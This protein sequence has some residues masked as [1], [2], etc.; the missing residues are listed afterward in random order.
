MKAS[1]PYNFAVM[2]PQGSGKGTQAE[3][4]A[5]KFKL[6]YIG[7]GDALRRLAKQKTPFGRKVDLIINKQGKLVPVSWVVELAKKEI[8]KTTKN[9]GLIFD[10]FARLLPE[11]K[12]INQTLKKAGRP[13]TAV[14]LIDISTKE[15]VKRLIR[16]RQCPNG[17]LFVS[18]VTL[19]KSQ[20]NC[21]RCGARIFQREDDRPAAIRERLRNY[22]RRTKPA[23]DYF[24]KEGLLVK[25]NGEQPVKKVFSDILRV[26]K[27][28]EK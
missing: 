15:T 3:L 4:L 6:K 1:K 7:A 26:I 9:Q 16:R 18:G 8:K 28:L 17:H 2:G 12:T 27:K 13:I 19:K 10:G 22:H 14:F 20:K 5:K 25:I 24:K 21:P 11:A 23:L